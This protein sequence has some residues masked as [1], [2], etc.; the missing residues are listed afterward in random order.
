MNHRCVVPAVT[1]LV[2]RSVGFVVSWVLGVGVVDLKNRPGPVPG[3]IFFRPW[4][5]S[6]LI[7]GKHPRCW[8]EAKEHFPGSGSKRDSGAGVA[9]QPRS[10]A[11]LGLGSVVLHPCSLFFPGWWAMGWCN[12]VCY[13]VPL[14]CSGELWNLILQLVRRKQSRYHLIDEDDN[15][16]LWY[17]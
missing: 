6:W 3:F 10:D 15:W 11:V 12:T 5:W 14:L 2:E 9:V 7:S 4:P 1:R 8:I 16:R 13:V 17:L